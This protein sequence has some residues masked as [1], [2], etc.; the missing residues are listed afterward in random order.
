MLCIVL[1]PIRYAY[2]MQCTFP[3]CHLLFKQLLQTLTTSGPC[4]E[5]LLFT[6]HIRNSICY[7][8]YQTI[9]YKIDMLTHSSFHQLVARYLSRK[10]FPLIAFTCYFICFCY[11][12]SEIFVAKHHTRTKQK[13]KIILLLRICSLQTHK[14]NFMFFSKVLD[15]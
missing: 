13:V 15:K 5:S 7:L 6:Y 4:I 9:I 11:L 8:W 1:G 3:F 12:P 14:F 10:S 2:S